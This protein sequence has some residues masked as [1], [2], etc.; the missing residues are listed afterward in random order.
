MFDEALTGSDYHLSNSI[1][2][3]LL[4]LFKILKFS[5]KRSP[6]EISQS[7]GSTRANIIFIRTNTIIFLLFAC[8]I[9]AI[10]KNRMNFTFV[11]RGFYL[12]SRSVRK[13]YKNTYCYIEYEQR[14]IGRVEGSRNLPWVTRV[15]E[16]PFS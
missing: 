1:L 7:Q 6:I 15:G 8:S 5:N 11:H 2:S 12:Y 9:K 14:T 10:P 16:S 3:S 4:F 13:V